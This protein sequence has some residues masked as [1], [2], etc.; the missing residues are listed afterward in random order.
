MLPTTTTEDLIIDLAVR[1]RHALEAAAQRAGA[2]PR[3]T[4]PPEVLAQLVE[5]QAAELAEGLRA[6]DAAQALVDSLALM[7][8]V[9]EDHVGPEGM[10]ATSP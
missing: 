10:R 1:G 6:G 9:G 7:L 2:P 5:V 4:G 8:A 3:L